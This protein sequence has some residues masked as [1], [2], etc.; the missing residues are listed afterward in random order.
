MGRISGWVGFSVVSSVSEGLAL[1]LDQLFSDFQPLCAVIVKGDLEI[2]IKSLVH[3]PWLQ[4]GQR[5][6][7]VGLTTSLGVPIARHDH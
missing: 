2:R 6:S 3:L 4:C 7:V 1:Q 5:Y